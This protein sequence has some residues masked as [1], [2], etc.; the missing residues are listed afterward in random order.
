M[1]EQPKRSKPVAKLIPKTYQLKIELEG[2]SPPVWRRLQVPGDATLGWLHAAIQLSMGWTNSH[3][4]QFIVC[5][6]IF[7]DPLFE[8]NELDD[9]P[10]VFDEHKTLLMQVAPH[11]HSVFMY[12]Y[13]FGDSWEHI[14]KVE[15]IYDRKPPRGDVAKCLEGARACPPEDCGG[16]YGYA[17]MLEIVM[18][19]EHDEHESTLEW[20]GG[21]FDP[22]AFDLPTTNKYL[23]KLKWPQMSMEDLGEV[24]MK[25]YGG[26]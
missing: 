23:R 12:Q 15:M 5:D 13:D 2:V 14:I 7:S 25:R 8:M 26:H 11:M 9:D 16:P 4:H 10:P 1:K 3:L 21:K 17:D 18:D 22:E 20:L 19:P 24:L 6:R